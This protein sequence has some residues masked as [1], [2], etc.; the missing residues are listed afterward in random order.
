MDCPV[1]AE[2]TRAV[3]DRRNRSCASSKMAGAYECS[4]RRPTA[5]EDAEGNWPPY[6]FLSLSL[7]ISYLGDLKQRST[8]GGRGTA[9]RRFVIH[10]DVWPLRSDSLSFEKRFSPAEKPTAKK[11]RVITTGTART[12]ETDRTPTLR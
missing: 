12:T 5:R 4:D 6:L 10:Y 2:R 1:A 7:S 9:S 11:T 8:L 3:I